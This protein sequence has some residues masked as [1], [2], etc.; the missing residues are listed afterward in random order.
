MKRILFILLCFFQIALLPGVSSQEAAETLPFLKADKPW[1]KE[2]FVN[3]MAS[4]GIRFSGS[5]SLLSAYLNNR[6]FFGV[7]AVEMRVNFDQEQCLE[8]IDI[9]YANKGDSA[10]IRNMHR[11]ISR[12]GKMLQTHLTALYG[13]PV[14]KKYGLKRISNRG[15]S[16]KT[17]NSEIIL[18]YVR[19]EYVVLHIYTGGQKGA[20]AVREQNVNAKKRDVS[21]QVKKNEFGDVYIADIPMVNQGSKG[22]CVPATVERVLRHYGITSLSMHFIADKANTGRG[23]G[24]SMKNVTQALAPIGRA[25]NLDVVS[26]GEVRISMIKKYVDK[27]VPVFWSMYVN[28]EYEAIR[29]A[30]RTKRKQARSPKAWLKE[31]RQLRV[32]GRGEAH[33][34]LVIGYNAETEEIAVSNSWG[35]SEIEPTWVPLRIAK[36][37]SQGRTFVL[38]PR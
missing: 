32:P 38:Y 8:S 16:W 34:C 27:G 13:A 25:V 10:E 15:I 28:R 6:K 17:G 4:K 30:S 18:E 11:T 36:K 19:N 33:M 9:M 37:V 20:A 5:K 21:K 3:F 7:P 35:A 1:S 12:N 29:H 22:Y 26:T 31:L 2:Q 14:R 23:G 24:T